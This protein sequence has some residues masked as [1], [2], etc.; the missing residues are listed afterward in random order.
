LKA[1]ANLPEFIRD[2]VRA[3]MGKAPARIREEMPWY[4]EL[5]ATRVT[6][7]I[8]EWLAYEQSRQEFEVIGTEIANTCSIAGVSLNL[9]LDRLDRLNDKSLLVIDYKTGDVSPKAWD[10]PRPEDVQLPL[11]AGFGIGA[12]EEIGGLAFAKV[13]AGEMCFAGQIGAARATVDS[14]LKGTSSLVKYPLMLDQ[15]LAWR[16]EI[17]QLARD[18]LSGRADVN[19]KDVTK[20]CQR[21]GLQTLCRVNERVGV[22]SDEETESVDD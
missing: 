22:I 4:L 18:F 8:S 14:S 17:E 19:P 7:L 1:I 20:T 12:G 16:E 5:E 9:R 10:L 11:Y 6:R 2:H 21:C 3:A 15:L 13:S